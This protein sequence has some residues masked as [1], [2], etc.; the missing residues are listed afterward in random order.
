[1][2]RTQKREVSLWKDFKWIFEDWSWRLQTYGDA[3]WALCG[4]YHNLVVPFA[5]HS[6]LFYSGA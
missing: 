6:L 3:C 4:K 1:M 2:L 5:S